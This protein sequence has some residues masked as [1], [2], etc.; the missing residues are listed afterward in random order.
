MWKNGL[1]YIC[2]TPPKISMQRFFFFVRREL[3]D[4]FFL[5]RSIPSIPVGLLFLSAV[6]MNMLA[7]KELFSLPYIA[8]DC[9][10]IFSWFSFLCMDMICKRFGAMAAMKV[11]VVAMFVNLIICGV[12]NLLSRMPG[13]WGEFYSY[14]ESNPE[15]AR[16]ANDALNVTFGGAWYVVL[17]SSLAM[18]ISAAVNTSINHGISKLVSP[19]GFRSFAVRSYV[20]TMIGQFADNLVFS[21]VV[22]HVFF[23]WTMGQV[24]V[25]AFT[26]ATVELLCEIIF[27][28][29]GYRI[30]M[31]WERLKVGEDYIRSHSLN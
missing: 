19:N 14:V 1:F 5:L 10:Y 15:F 23:G 9:G 27:S 30:A 8:L 11:S 3:D 31:N 21:T 13:K 17:G 12:F 25:C 16:V 4:V 20:S 6:C 18:L 28:P 26:G 24:V 2:P 29:L 7:N 22:S